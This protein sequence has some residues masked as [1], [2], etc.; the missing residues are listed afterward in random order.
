ME[1]EAKTVKGIRNKGIRMQKG[2]EYKPIKQ[3]A[4]L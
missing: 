3:F 2:Q 1:L 4:I